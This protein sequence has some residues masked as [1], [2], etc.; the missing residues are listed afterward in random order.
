MLGT[1]VRPD[2]GGAPR[3]RREASHARPGGPAVG[4]EESTQLNWETEA[5]GSLWAPEA[6][7][8]G[9]R[10]AHGSPAGPR[11]LRNLTGPGRRGAD[12]TRVKVKGSWWRH[13]TLRKAVGV[14]L[15]VLGGIVV[16]SAVAVVM[17][18]EQTPVPTAAMAATGYC[19]PWSTPR[20]ARWSAG[21]APPTGRC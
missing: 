9:R 17:A 4:A 3:A 6:P 18:Y 2:H 10:A 11:G 19:S 13:W 16:L 5:T 1:A 14:L 20:A 7:V 12:R 15:A 8:R 21:S